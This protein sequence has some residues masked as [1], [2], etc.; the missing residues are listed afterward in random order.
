MGHVEVAVVDTYTPY[1][2]MAVVGEGCVVV[3]T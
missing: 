2:D 1:I 3:A